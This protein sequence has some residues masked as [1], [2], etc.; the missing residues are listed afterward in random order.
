M[1]KTCYEMQIQTCVW[2]VKQV[3]WKLLPPHTHTKQK[4]M[5]NKKYEKIYFD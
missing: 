4:V 3:L 5:N 2:I 1:N